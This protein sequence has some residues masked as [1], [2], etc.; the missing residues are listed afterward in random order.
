VSEAGPQRVWRFPASKY[1]S[2]QSPNHAGDP[3]FLSYELRTGGHH[4]WREPDGH[5]HWHIHTGQLTGQNAGGDPAGDV[6][7]GYTHINDVIR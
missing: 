1:C 3:R 4:R 6:V 7:D 2:S 5:S